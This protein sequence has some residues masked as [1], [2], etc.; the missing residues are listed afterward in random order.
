VPA[1]NPTAARI[2]HQ[3]DT[4]T[5]RRDEQVRDAEA[6]GS[7]RGGD[8]T[9]PG[10]LPRGDPDADRTPYQQMH[11]DIEEQ[12]LVRGQLSP[13]E[14]HD[15][16]GQDLPGGNRAAQAGLA[17]QAIAEHPDDRARAQ[18]QYT[19]ATARQLAGVEMQDPQRQAFGVAGSQNPHTVVEAWG[20]D[21]HKHAWMDPEQR[22]PAHPGEQSAS[23]TNYDAG[24]AHALGE[25]PERP[26]QP[27]REG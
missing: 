14:L 1:K 15:V 12:G 9:N 11:D 18:A 21:W 6:I 25:S 4:E 3:A 24:I 2:E 16:A 20:A 27:R 10:K 7:V 5:E 17:R 23:P 26:G 8:Y 13:R 19:D 22:P